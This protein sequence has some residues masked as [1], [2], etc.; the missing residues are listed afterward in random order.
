MTVIVLILLACLSLPAL[1]TLSGHISSRPTVTIDSGVVIGSATS[2]P[3]SLGTVNHFLGIPF[4]EPPLRF[5]PPKA[6]ASWKSAFDASSYGPACIQ[7]FNYPRRSRDDLLKWAN[8]PGPA[9]GESE[10]CLTLNVFAP[11]TLGEGRKAVIVWIYGGGFIF[12]A[13]SLPG[14]DGSSLAANQDVVVVTINY[15]TNVF[16]FAN[17]SNLPKAKRNLGLLDQRLALDWVQRNIAAFGGDPSRVTIAG[18]SAGAMSVDALIAKPPVPVP[19]RAAILQSGQ[20]SFSISGAS[21]A[22]WSTLL[23]M[24]NCAPNRDLECL[25]A[26]PA[27]KLKGIIERSALTFNPISDGTTWPLNTRGARLNS[28]EKCSQIARVPV[29][30][31]SNGDEGR[32]FVG[33]LNSTAL[34]SMLGG[35][36]ADFWQEILNAYPIG[37]PG[38]ATQADRISKIITDVQFRCP[39]ELMTDDSASVGISAWRY[40]YNASF[41]NTQLY[42]EPVAYHSSEISTIFGTFPHVNATMAQKELSRIMQKAWADF[43]KEPYY[44]PGWAAVPSVEVFSNGRKAI[45]EGVFGGLSETVDSSEFDARCQLYQN[46]YDLEQ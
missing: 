34:V 42:P 4:S 28:T 29:L 14:Y 24:T 5:S 45:G 39:A 18:E 7:Q 32:T 12:G 17:S 31:G 15:R 44:G 22:S 26:I 21:E 33:T 16:G 20:T 9:A 3:P 27:T 35:L 36:K 8:T 37:A 1:G 10:D 23:N 41:P 46:L 43:A 30:V 6:V 13:S 11:A 2:I 19:F 25:R 38:I 40:I